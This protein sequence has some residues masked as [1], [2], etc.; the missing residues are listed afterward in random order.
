VKPAASYVATGAVAHAPAQ[1]DEATNIGDKAKNGVATVTK[2][3]CLEMVIW[4]LPLFCA[5]LPPHTPRIQKRSV[6]PYRQATKVRH[7]IATT[8]DFSKVPLV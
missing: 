4:F 5:R 1:A 3:K 2:A 8:A 6:G 7:Y